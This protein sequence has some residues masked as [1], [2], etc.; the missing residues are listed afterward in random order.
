MVPTALA[1]QADPEKSGDDLTAFHR[2]H[3]VSSS[4]TAV[5]EQSLCRTPE[6]FLWCIFNNRL[7]VLPVPIANA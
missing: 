5:E 3:L 4:E 6:T 1:K 2:R 7:E